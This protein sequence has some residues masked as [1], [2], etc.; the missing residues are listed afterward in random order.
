[1]PLKLVSGVEQPPAQR[2][3][4]TRS[5]DQRRG[6]ESPISDLDLAR[7]NRTNILGVG[8]DDVVLRL[9][10]S[11]WRSLA[12]PIVVRQRGESFRLLPAAR[13]VGTI[14][15]YDIDSLTCDEQLALYDWMA[16][17]GRTQVVSTSS[18]S[19]LPK[20]QTGAFNEGLYYRLNVLTLDLTSPVER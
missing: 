12:T 16:G 9:V 2:A 4:M 8:N 14:I 19:L 3:L 18:T 1:M 7:L 15:V 10:A 6:A 5:N 11:L 17:N 20:L 13:P